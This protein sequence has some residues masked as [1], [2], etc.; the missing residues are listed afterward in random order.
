MAT[1]SNSLT[2]RMLVMGIEAILF[3]L[4]PSLPGCRWIS[5]ERIARE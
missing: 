5:D 4:S 1:V 2:C 3:P